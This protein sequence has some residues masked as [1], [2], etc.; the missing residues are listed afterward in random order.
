MLTDYWV[1]F[2][3]LSRR[4]ALANPSIYLGVYMPIPNHQKVRIGQS[5]HIPWCVYANPKSA[6]IT[7]TI[8]VLVKMISYFHTY[9]YWSTPEHN[10]RWPHIMQRGNW[11]HWRR[12]SGDKGWDWNDATSTRKTKECHIL[13]ATQKLERG[14]RGSLQ[15]LRQ[16]TALPTP[17]TSGLQ[18]CKRTHPCGFKSPSLQHFVT[19][20]W[21]N[22]APC[23]SFSFFVGITWNRIHQH[24]YVCGHK[25]IAVL[26]A[27][28]VWNHMTYTS[29]EPQYVPSIHQ[30][31]VNRELPSIVSTENEITNYCHI[32]RQ[33]KGT[34]PKIAG[35]SIQKCVGYLIKMQCY[36]EFPS[37]L[38]S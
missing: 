37:W 4:P 20:S 21:R 10:D 16:S 15:S 23:F 17:W 3:V 18:A 36:Q 22:T 29:Y 6:I 34:Q 26:E 28:N 13:R 2:S 31:G 25:P 1:E 5:F 12:P 11:T 8:K 35:K 38:S 19:A 7:V 24:S 9:S 33:S 27:L 14:R 30:D 32:L